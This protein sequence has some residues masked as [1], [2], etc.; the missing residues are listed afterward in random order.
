VRACPSEARL[1]VAVPAL[2]M[3]VPS[4]VPPSANVT[5]PLLGVAALGAMATTV[6]VKLICWAYVVELAELTSETLVPA[7]LTVNVPLT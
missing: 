6:A 3:A 5:V 7:A 4:V 2:S 1:N